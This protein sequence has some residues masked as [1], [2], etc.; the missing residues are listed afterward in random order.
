[1]TTHAAVHVGQ[2]SA[3][4]RAAGFPALREAFL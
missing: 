2:V 4:R 3:W 1:L